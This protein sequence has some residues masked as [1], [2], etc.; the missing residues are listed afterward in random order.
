M[1]HF[2]VLGKTSEFSKD[3]EKDVKLKAALVD[4]WGLQREWGEGHS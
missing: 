4:K 2:L 3:L 1:Y